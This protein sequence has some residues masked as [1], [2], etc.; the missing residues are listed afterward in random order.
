MSERPRVAFF[1]TPSF[2]VPILEALHR[3]ADV[4]LVVTQENKQKGRGLRAQASPVRRWADER[5]LAVITP[6]RLSDPEFLAAFRAVRPD[7]AVLAAYGKIVPESV[8]SVPPHGFVNIHPSLLPRH[9]GAAPVAAAILAGDAM[10]GITLIRLDVELDHGPIIAQEAIPVEPHEHR[11]S[12]ERRLAVQGAAM[13]ECLLLP[14]LKSNAT[15]REQDH[16]RA[17]YTKQLAR[18]DGRVDWRDAAETIERKI[19]AFDPWPGTFTAFTGTLLKILD[20]VAVRGATRTWPAGTVIDHS[21]L[22]AVV[23]GSGLL[24][25]TSVQTPGGAAM[26]AAAFVRGRRTFIG[27]VL[28]A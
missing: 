17:T 24:Q 21:G 13:L 14:Y 23:C 12:L 6:R 5:R 26:S 10:T 18:D 28:G 25:L 9:R 20:G 16:R 4:E 3:T 22:P 2:A 11:P 8:L 1:G 7:V 15:L 27:A 19:R